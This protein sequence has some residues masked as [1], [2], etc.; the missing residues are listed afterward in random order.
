MRA[1]QVS[2]GR[3]YAVKVSGRI[4]PV[5]L[6]GPSVFGGWNGTNLVSG[7]AVRVKTAGRLRYELEPTSGDELRRTGRE[8][9]PVR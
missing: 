8:Y 2:I 5:R 7:R 6:E 4:V 1:S 9:R 3:T